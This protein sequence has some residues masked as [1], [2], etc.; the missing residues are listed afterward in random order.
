MV[1]AIIYGLFDPRK[2]LWLWEVRYIGQTIQLPNTRLSGHLSAALADPDGTLNEWI[3][4]LMVRGHRPVIVAF[5]RP[6][7]DDL[8]R[9]ER[10]WVKEGRRQG[11]ALLNERGGGESHRFSRGRKARP[12]DEIYWSH[13]IRGS[14]EDACWAWSS[15]TD[16]FGYG[17]FYS[18][19][20]G[21]K[22]RWAA[23]RF[24]WVLHVGEIPADLCV[25][26]RCDNP[27]CSNP[28]HLFLGTK[29]DN[30][31]D[32]VAKGR[33]KGKRKNPK[34]HCLRGHLLSGDNV[35]LYRGR[36]I[37]QECRRWHDRERYRKEREQ[38][39][40]TVA[41]RH[42]ERTHCPQGH[43]YS[44][45]NTYITK[46]G[47]RQCKSCAKERQVNSKKQDQ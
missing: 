28:A 13:V 1:M 16:P 21:T 8:N 26:H 22:R 20:G 30:S 9:R 25:C 35:I 31:R 44:P 39:G 27:P 29:A 23:H 5:E 18:S 46:A 34:T 36:R 15:T 24:S 45:D 6:S 4:D 33:M 43:P 37:C 19:W 17:I 10:I 3:L 11:W 41:L 38:D 14:V 42:S 32:A 40:F 2:P 12:P 7:L 47:T